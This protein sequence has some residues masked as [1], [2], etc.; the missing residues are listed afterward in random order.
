MDFKIELNED[1]TKLYEPLTSNKITVNWE[2][3]LFHNDYNSE[4]A[5]IIYRIVDS[6]KHE[7]NKNDIQDC[8]NLL[9]EK[10]LN[11]DRKGTPIYGNFIKLVYY[12]YINYNTKLRPYFLSLEDSFEQSLNNFS[13]R[14]IVVYI[15]LEI[16][17]LL[18]FLFFFGINLFFLIYSN[19]YIFQNILYMFIDFTQTQNYSF[20]NKY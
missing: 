2:N 18:S 20:N 15:I 10:Y 13:T 16:I 19:K 1:F 14:T 11:I 12:F 9:L 3:K 7:F 17:A 6:I 5:L 8:E 4:L